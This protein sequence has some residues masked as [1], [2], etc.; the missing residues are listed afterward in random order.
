[1]NSLKTL[2]I[3]ASEN[4]E[5]YSNMAIKKLVKHGHPVFAIGNKVGAVDEII[6]EI[7][8]PIFMD[9]HT[10]SLYIRPDLQRDY[11]DY[12]KQLKPKRVIF[13]PG[14]EN[15]QVENEF[16]ESGIEIIEACTLVLLSIDR[17]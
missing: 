16:I 2:V 11:V 14:T 3:G 4:P 1:M 6:I 13:N 7:G 5:R 8:R 10:V 12:I 15:V 17:Y 9:I